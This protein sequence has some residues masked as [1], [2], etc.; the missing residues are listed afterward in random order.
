VTGRRTNRLVAIAAGIAAGVLIAE[1]G[2]S[3]FA[4]RSLLRLGRSDVPSFR[5]RMLDEERVKAAAVSEGPFAYDVDP[6]VSTR[7]KG[8]FTYRFADVAATTDRTGQRVRRGPAPEPGASRIVVL[9]D[10]VAFGF[11]VA[12]DETLAHCLEELLGATMEEGRPRP[13]AFTVACPGWSFRNAQRYLLDHLQ[14]IDP[15]VVLYVPADND[16]DDSHCVLETG[17]RVVDVDPALGAE[18]PHCSQGYHYLL[19][20]N[21][22][23]KFPGTEGAYRHYALY[24][25]VTPES[26]RRYQTLIAGIV[27]LQDRLSACGSRFA[28][29]LLKGVPFYRRVLHALAGERPFPLL[30]VFGSTGF[31]DQ[32]EG[33]PHPNARCVRATAWRMA[34][35]LIEQRWVA[36]AGTRPLPDEDARYA[37]R[38]FPT[39]PTDELEAERAAWDHLAVEQI[40]NRIDM[41]KGAGWHQVYGGVL[42]DGTVGI[43]AFAV[44]SSGGASRLAVTIER[45]DLPG[46]YPMT[47]RVSVN[48]VDAKP[49]DVAAADPGQDRRLTSLVEIPPAARGSGFLEVQLLS[50]SWAVEQVE[51]MSRLVSYRLRS[52][53][54]VE[55]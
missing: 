35:F 29:V 9:G 46:V 44:L 52:L 31:E 23:R 11:G 37:G 19:E 38:T 16:L 18:H 28:V 4:G 15:D 7:M 27:E 24:T 26:K 48:G 39:S 55:P 10:S 17:H 2:V 54:V 30:G 47:V 3:L 40:G 1:G 5:L 43:A 41:E 20:G 22:Q 32:L 6:L 53:A 25:G 14:E 50:S 42:P 36:G 21:R 12:D 49:I 13:V 8:G 33:D 51:G 45:A 34:R